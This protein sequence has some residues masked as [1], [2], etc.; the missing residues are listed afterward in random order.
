MQ[1]AVKVAVIKRGKELKAVQAY[2][3]RIG[4]N[5]F[6]KV[7][8]G[9]VLLVAMGK[10]AK[11]KTQFFSELTGNFYQ[12]LPTQSVPAL[13]INGVPMHRFAKVGPKEHTKRI[14]GAASPRGR[15]L[16]ICTGLGYTAIAAA[17]TGRV[18]EVSTIEKDSEVLRIAGMNE[19]STEL[20]RNKKIRIVAGDAA[21]KIREF[22]PDTFDCVIHDPPTF[23][24]TPQLYTAKFYKEIL[25]VMKKG[26][27]LWHYAAEPGKAGRKK[28]PEKLALRIM[29]GL[30]DAGFSEIMLDRDSAGVVASK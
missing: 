22:A 16:D 13:R 19:A 2:T 14:I 27:V 21:E 23:V 18:K 15:V 12:L 5:G 1:F 10:S 25:R 3:N 26:G 29:N 20:F 24:M 6:L 7:I 9:L 4:V 11:P 28:N 8:A 30:K 17:R